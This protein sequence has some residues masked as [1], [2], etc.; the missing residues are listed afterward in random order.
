VSSKVS[1]S[2]F[3]LVELLVVIGIILLLM[4][5]LL[6]A[7][8]KVREAANRMTCASKLRQLGFA[9]HHYHTARRRLPPGY[10]GP[11]LANNTNSPAFYYEGQWVGHFPMLLPYVEQDGLRD[12]ITVIFR[13]GTVTAEKWFW[14]APA[15]GPG[16]PNVTNYTAAMRD[17]TIF[18]CPSAANFVPEFNNPGPAGGGTFL[19]LHVYNS[20]TKGAFTAGWK[21]EYGTAAAYRPLGRTNYTGVAGCGSGTHPF[22]QK[23]AGI[24][25]NRTEHTLGQIS[26][27]DGTSHT[28]LYGETC[29]THWQSPL[30]TSDICWMAGG[31]MGTYLGLHHG[32]TAP[33][34]AFSSYHTSGVQFCFAD[35]SVRTV[36]YGN[37][38][39]NGL[40]PTF[41]TDWHLL[42]Q[43]AGWRDGGAAD[44]TE[45]VD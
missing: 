1:R 30:E 19:G 21:D 5:I 42:Q 28:L 20:P 6:P 36:R 11:S 37:T 23:F 29:G 24:Y 8:Q 44:V 9:A 45:L 38:R 35:G 31:G 34:I 13:I 7:V 10:L 18:R 39:W 27:C 4:G 15:T 17:L 33:V 32:R 26:V 2:G 25:T 3:T 43:L 16:P 12:Q 41:T 22:F 14:N 40:S